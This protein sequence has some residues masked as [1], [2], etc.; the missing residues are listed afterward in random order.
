MSHRVGRADLPRPEQ[1]LDHLDHLDR[2]V[3]HGDSSDRSDAPAARR[4]AIPHEHRRQ[5]RV[6]AL[7]GEVVAHEL[8]LGVGAA[9]ARAQDQFGPDGVGQPALVA[10]AG[11]DKGDGDD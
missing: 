10:E 3:G 11:D 5:R 9:R 1:R 8:I 7:A 6:V 4:G 2:H